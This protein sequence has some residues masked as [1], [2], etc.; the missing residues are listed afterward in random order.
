MGYH[1]DTCGCPECMNYGQTYNP[2]AVH[3][4]SCG[5]DQCNNYGTSRVSAIANRVLGHGAK[6]PVSSE[7]SNVL[8]RFHAE[9]QRWVSSY[10]QVKGTEDLASDVL[11]R[12]KERIPENMLKQIGAAFASGW[13]ESEP[14]P[15]RSHLSADP[16][17][18]LKTL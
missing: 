17:K 13:L 3:N 12:L 11:Q 4:Q 10:N 18:R 1:N 7:V 2:S 6:T 5:C 16:L 14:E 15:H 9:F 8:D